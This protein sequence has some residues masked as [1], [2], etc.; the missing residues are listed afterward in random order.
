MSR[1]V[2]GGVRGGPARS[3]AHTVTMHTD[4]RALMSD[5]SKLARSLREKAESDDA[6]ADE[7]YLTL[8]SGELRS[9]EER[10]SVVRQ[11]WSLR[12]RA[13]LSVAVVRSLDNICSTHVWLARG[14]GNHYPLR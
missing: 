3:N 1:C 14:E 10:E 6:L 2:S 11:Y 12:A 8:T 9:V 7:L 4:V 13:H 5:L